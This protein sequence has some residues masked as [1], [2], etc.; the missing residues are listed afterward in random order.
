VAVCGMLRNCLFPAQFPE[1]WDT[2]VHVEMDAVSET[3]CGWRGG[4]G[5]GGQA[6][7]TDKAAAKNNGGSFGGFNFIRKKITKETQYSKNSCLSIKL[8]T[9]DLHHLTF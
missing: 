4:G 3:I 7:A 1:F 5:G 8:L 2:D 6:R 9:V